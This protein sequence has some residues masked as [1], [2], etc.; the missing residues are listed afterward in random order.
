MLKS[1]FDVDYAPIR[2]SSFDVRRG[3]RLFTFSSERKRMSVLMVNGTKKDSGVSYTKGAAEVVV[4][5]CTRW[6]RAVCAM[7]CYRRAMFVQY[8]C[9]VVNACPILC[10][11]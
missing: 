2:A 7:A 6:V 10:H 3:D 1:V 11:P 5:C 4:G 8:F 9:F